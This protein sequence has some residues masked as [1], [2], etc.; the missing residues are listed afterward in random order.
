MNIETTVLHLISGFC[1]LYLKIVPERFSF[2]WVIH[3]TAY[4]HVIQCVLSPA[5]FY[6]FSELTG[7]DE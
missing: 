7:S 6:K 5:G 3:V 1:S 2:C 4:K